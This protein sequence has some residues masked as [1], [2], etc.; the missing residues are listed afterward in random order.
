MLD[1]RWAGP[2]EVVG[3]GAADVSSGACAAPTLAP[4]IQTVE[5]FKHN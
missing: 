2:E 3:S 4:F 1:A 5:E